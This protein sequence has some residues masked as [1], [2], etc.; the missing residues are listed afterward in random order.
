MKVRCNHILYGKVETKLV[1]LQGMRNEM[2][3]S[4][5]I[6]VSFSRTINT[7]GPNDIPQYYDSENISKS[8]LS[9]RRATSGPHTHWRDDNVCT[10]VL[11][12]M[13]RCVTQN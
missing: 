6:Y 12:G 9:F 2:I 11:Y 1:K 7:Q 5:F 3:V 4:S 13:D 8:T 10:K